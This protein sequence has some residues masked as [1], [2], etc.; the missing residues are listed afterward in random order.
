MLVP[1]YCGSWVP[2]R[3]YTPKGMVWPADAGLQPPAPM[4]FRHRSGRVGYPVLADP[5]PE[6]LVLSLGER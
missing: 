5:Y 2:L 6:M 3:Q 4:D 1:T